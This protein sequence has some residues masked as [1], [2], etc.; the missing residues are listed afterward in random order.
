MGRIFYSQAFAPP[1]PAIRTE[2]ELKA[3]GCQRW[4]PMNRFDPDS[5][6]FF[7]DAEYEAFVDP[8]QLAREQAEMAALAAAEGS[9]DTSD[10]SD[11][12]ESEQGSPMAVGS[13]DP[14]ILIADAYTNRSPP[15]T[16]SEDMTVISPSTPPPEWPN[17]SPAGSPTRDEWEVFSSGTSEEIPAFIPPASLRAP[18]PNIEMAHSRDFDSPMPSL[19]ITVRRTVNITPIPVRPDSGARSPSPESLAAPLTRSPIPFLS[20]S[21]P[22]SVSPRFY[23]WQGYRMPPVPASPTRVR[24]NR[25]GPLTNPHARMSFARI[26]SAPVPIRVTSSVM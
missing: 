5:E 12:A 26:D 1:A 4:N 18:S 6:D 23:S 14:A 17:S 8:A 21:P 10:S 22:P 25:D 9:S 20:P 19:P 13:D 16:L 15:F 2:P 11:S 24:G 7:Q 3:D